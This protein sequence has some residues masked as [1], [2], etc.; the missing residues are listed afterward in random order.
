MHNDET[1]AKY[2][3]TLAKFLISLLRCTFAVETDFKFPLDT[4]Q[5]KLA[6]KLYT[7]AVKG[8][9]LEEHIQRFALSLLTAPDEQK[10]SEKWSC[11]LMCFLAVD[12]MRDDGGFSEAHHLTS[13]LANW[14]YIIRGVALYEAY[15]TAP[16]YS[17][18]IL[19]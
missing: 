12:N 4:H 18:G 5:T 10:L 19:G 14:K 15:I 13:D 3:S 1:L 16:T 11:S 9:N 6:K 17:N 8:D 2:G 7:L